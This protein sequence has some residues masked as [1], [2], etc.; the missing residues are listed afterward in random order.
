ML[1]KSISPCLSAQ[2]ANNISLWAKINSKIP[3]MEM[4]ENIEVQIRNKK[5]L[6][7]YIGF[8]Y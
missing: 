1:L 3:V 2:S 8:F 7:I 5:N 6:Q 4:F